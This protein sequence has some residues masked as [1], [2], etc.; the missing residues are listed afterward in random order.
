MIFKTGVS[1]LVMAQALFVIL[2][3]SLQGCAVKDFTDRD[4]ELGSY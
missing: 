3:I 2:E 4:N 1:L